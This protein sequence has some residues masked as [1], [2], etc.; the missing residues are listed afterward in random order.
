MKKTLTF[1][2]LA[3]VALLLGSCGESKEQQEA[4]QK[5]QKL[6]AANKEL[7]EKNEKHET[8]LRG[9]DNDIKSIYDENGLMVVKEENEDTYSAQLM[10]IKE[11]LAEYRANLD[12]MQKELEQQKDKNNKLLAEVR[13]L[14]AKIAEKERFIADLQAELVA[15]NEQIA[16]LND[17]VNDLNNN[18]EN[19]NKEIDNLR[20]QNLAQVNEMNAVYYVGA[21]KKELKSQ[22]VIISPKNILKSEVPAEAFTKADKRDLN[23]IV[24]NTKK[25][26]VLS[27]HPDGTYNLVKGVDENGNKIVTLEI[28]NPEL[29]WTVTKYLVVLT[30]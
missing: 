24:F 11:T 14:K 30:K 7:A 23:S 19:A 16:G 9:I 29:F 28:T 13:S 8:T 18:L 6:E 21:T 3:L 25:A 4:V 2:S 15:K 22:G 5:Q 20:N 17:R 10:Q 12:E 27:N 26:V 1:V